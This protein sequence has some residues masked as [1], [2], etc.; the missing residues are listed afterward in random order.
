[1]NMR[2]MQRVS[3]NAEGTIQKGPMADL[4]DVKGALQS[5]KPIVNVPLPENGKWLGLRVSRRFTGGEVDTL[6]VSFQIQL[7]I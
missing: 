4:I 3:V 5:Y 1:M 2:A 7:A 6:S